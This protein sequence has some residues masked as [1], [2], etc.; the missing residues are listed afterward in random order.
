MTSSPR[1]V[2]AGLLLAA[3]LL[4]AGCGARQG[5]VTG[6]VSHRNGKKVAPGSVPL[7]PSTGLASSTAIQA[8]GTYCIPNVPAGL[9]KAG[10]VSPNPRPTVLSRPGTVPGRPANLARPGRARPPVPA[11]VAKN[12]FPIKDVLADPQKS[13]LTVNVQRGNTSFDIPVE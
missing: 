8:D 13:N 7:V 1:P 4:T 3:A 12:W 6:T 9:A 2:F 11:E 5:T 10:I